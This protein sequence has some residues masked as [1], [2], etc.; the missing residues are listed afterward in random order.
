MPTPDPGEPSGLTRVGIE[1][2]Y[3]RMEKP[4]FN[5]VYRRLWNAQEAQ[6][7]V[8]EAFLRLWHHRRALRGP[9][10]DAWLYRAALNLASHRR[11]FERLRRW[12]GL[13]NADEMASEAG[14]DLEAREREL[15]V[16]AAVDALPDKL[17][18]ALLLT[19]FSEMSYTEVGRALGIPAGTVAS[20]RHLALRRLHAILGE[21]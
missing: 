7:V 10:I 18:R 11:R 8:Q 14:R 6:D 1:E 2:L 17:R 21:A 19:E 3:R 5:V 12:T 20:R 9:T 15:R 16:R 4:L 13:E